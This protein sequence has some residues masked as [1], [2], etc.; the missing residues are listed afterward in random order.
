M[1]IR[2]KVDAGILQKADRLFRNDDR[3]IFIEIL[4]N[5]RR[6]G[7]TTVEVTIHPTDGEE[8]SSTVSV[9]DNGAGIDDF[10]DLVTLGRS[11]WDAQTQ[12][13]EDPAGMGLFSLCQSG[14]EISSGSRSVTISQDVFLGNATAEVTDHPY[15]AGTRLRFT[16]SSNH[17]SLKNAL[18]AVS[19]FGPL[20]VRVNGESLQRYDFLEG[21]IHREIIDGIEIGFA[22]TFSHQ[23]GIH[24]P[25]NWNFYGALI[26]EHFPPFF[27]FLDPGRAN[28]ESRL[29]A[30]FN[31]LETGRIKLQLPDRRSVIR[32]DFLTAFERKARAAAYRCFQKQAQHALTFARWKEARDLG[33]VLPEA[34]RLLT[35]WTVPARDDA[36][37][38]LFGYG[39]KEI[40]SNLDRVLLV[41]SALENEY[42]LQAALHSG[43]TLDFLLYEEK[44]EFRGYSWYDALPLLVNAA[45]L[46]DGIPFA[47][48]EPAAK[49]NRPNQ[50]EVVVRIE[51]IGE[52]AK[53]LP[54]PALVH[55]DE[56]QVNDLSFV[57]VKDSP[58]DK[59]GARPFWLADFLMWATFQSSDDLE[60]DSWQ[61]QRDY[62]EGFI[63]ETLSDYFEGPR[64]SLLLQLNRFLG[65]GIGQQATRLGVTEIKL[66]RPIP[67]EHRWNIELTGGSKEEP[68]GVSN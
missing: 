45:V 52:K 3:G 47:E 12:K 60:C 29:N 7:A 61:T 20:D 46:V 34:A 18:E 21:A 5:A 28:S 8:N 1:E 36:I 67:E 35:N 59:S 44:P 10:Q 53:S 41:K 15:V 31:V 6:A 48:C 37:E 9:M 43:A 42:T 27:G 13:T 25:E 11:G 2:G 32:S 39:E 66:S 64:S 63:E 68:P 33:V 16:R 55:V 62:Y 56:E 54:L 30:R 49:N 14:V 24:R 22:I 38:P 26:E 4:Q 17:Q 65:S 50:I 58:W 19:R 23:V 51:Q 40:L 57:V